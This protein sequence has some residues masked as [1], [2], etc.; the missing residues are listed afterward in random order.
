MIITFNG[1]EGSGKSTVAQK[2]AEFLDIPRFYM[3][4]IF[5]DV[6]K[7]KGL[8]LVEYLKSGE[9]NPDVD[10]EVDE[11][12]Y[13]LSQKNN[14]CVIEGRT[15]FHIIPH[16]LKIYLKVDLTEGAERVYNQLQ[17][18]DSRNEIK[19]EVTLEKV[20]SKIKE[21][22]ET[23]NKRYKMYYG[24]DIRDENNY[25]FILD[26]TQLSREEVFKKIEEFV[27]ANYKND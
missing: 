27:S 6:A 9:T 13:Q 4:Q 1:D 3:G 14:N 21:R 17:E 10:K 5:R 12:M 19:N 22:R 20:I 24:I 23:D 2:I 26:T 16:S 11:Y 15:A 18:E 8:T 7:K 25:D